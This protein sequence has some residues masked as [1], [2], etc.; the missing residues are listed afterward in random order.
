MDDHG[1]SQEIATVARELDPSRRM[2]GSN[3]EQEIVEA[4]GEQDPHLDGI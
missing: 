4:E 3:N 1:Y 2:E